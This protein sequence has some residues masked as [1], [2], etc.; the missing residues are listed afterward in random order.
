MT[1]EEEKVLEAQA[2]A[3]AKAAVGIK[4]DEK[5]QAKP[6]PSKAPE[7]RKEAMKKKTVSKGKP[8]PKAKKEEPHSFKP[9]PVVTLLTAFRDW[10]DKKV[11]LDKQGNY[12]IKA[13][14]KD[15]GPNAPWNKAIKAGFPTLESFLVSYKK[16]S[17]R[18]LLSNKVAVKKEKKAA[19]KSTKPA[20]AKK[21]KNSVLLRRRPIKEAIDEKDLGG[22]LI[23]RNTE[24]NRDL[25][26][27]SYVKGVPVDAEARY[28]IGKSV[29]YDTMQQLYETGL[30]AIQDHIV[31]ICPKIYL[32][33]ILAP[34]HRVPKARYLIEDVSPERALTR[35]RNEN[36]KRI[37]AK[38]RVLFNEEDVVKLLIPSFENSIM[39]V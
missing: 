17:K 23:R 15:K 13:N 21:E 36:E 27:A 24:T 6:S 3:L 35:I 32:I 38:K 19:A 16:A 39:E 1:T 25:P 8:K 37:K 10:R 34:R 18:G 31:N 28:A 4:E 26:E 20:L 7:E 22:R 30:K 11:Y 2:E 14:G 5:E 29:T 12:H 9:V 33:D